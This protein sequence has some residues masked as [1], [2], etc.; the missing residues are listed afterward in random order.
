MPACCI[1]NL[2]LLD[3]AAIARLGIEGHI[4]TVVKLSPD[5]NLPCTFD[6]TTKGNGVL[7]IG[8]MRLLVYDVHDNGH[9]YAGGL[10]SLDL[11]DLNADGVKELVVSVTVLTTDEKSSTVTE[12]RPFAFVYTYNKDTKQLMRTDSSTGYDITM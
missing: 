3:E 6:L 9:V 1:A 2:P 5:I 8:D 4:P 7:E 11:V 12:I 10:A